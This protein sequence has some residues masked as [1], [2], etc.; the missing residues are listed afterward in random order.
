MNSIGKEGIVDF[1]SHLP[2]KVPIEVDPG[3][4]N[5]SAAV[6]FNRCGGKL[7]CIQRRKDHASLIRVS[8]RVVAAGTEI[9][10]TVGFGVRH[11]LIVTQPRTDRAVP[12]PVHGGQRGVAY[13]RCGSEGRVTPIVFQRVRL[14]HRLDQIVLR[15]AIQV[16]SR[17]PGAPE[18]GRCFHQ[19]DGRKLF[20][21]ADGDADP[22]GIE[23]LS[24]GVP[25]SEL[26]RLDGINAR[27]RQQGHLILHCP[28]GHRRT[29]GAAMHIVPIAV[30]VPVEPHVHVH[31]LCQCVLHRHLILDCG[32]LAGRQNQ[33]K[34]QT[35]IGAIPVRRPLERIEVV[36]CIFILAD[37]GFRLQT[38][39]LAEIEHASGIQMNRSVR[40]RTGLVNRRIVRD[41]VRRIGEHRRACDAVR[42]IRGITEVL[43][44]LPFFIPRDHEGQIE[45]HPCIAVLVG[46]N[47]LDPTGSARD[48][49]D[50]IVIPTTLQA[51]RFPPEGAPRR[52]GKTRGRGI[53]CHGQP[54]DGS[55]LLLERVVRD[56][57]VVL[58]GISVIV[59][60]VQTPHRIVPSLETVVDPVDS[61][62]AGMECLGPQKA[63]RP[64]PTVVGRRD[65][66]V[67]AQDK[68]QAAR[69][70][71]GQNIVAKRSPE[72]DVADGTALG[73]FEIIRQG[74]LGQVDIHSRR[75]QV[76]QLRPMHLVRFAGRPIAGTA[77]AG[78]DRQAWFGLVGPATDDD[79][80]RLR[81]D[82][83]L[84]PEEQPT[85]LTHRGAKAHV[86]TLFAE[87]ARS[88]QIS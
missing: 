9:R 46:I 17:R 64:A 37:V 33:G 12:G 88:K 39:R 3:L 59:P 52:R 14:N 34:K 11:I 43:L 5:P 80:V 6:D 83:R 32:R 30:P 77:F 35:V 76:G 71:G 55:L 67:D 48:G 60:Q 15:L 45:R 23:L 50:G 85:V 25:T 69:A 27:P 56:A 8:R 4:D 38:D 81:P 44:G 63:A 36:H 58:E 2:C 13:C 74:D 41:H 42:T 24:C 29:V 82:I 86:S 7:A 18:P 68:G 75:T 79:A 78:G 73:T 61:V 87:L 47:H 54:V 19:D 10:L 66:R 70:L 72:M 84:A 62:L 40:R 53:T 51:S 49:L 21:L 16:A 1:L 26:R 31:R 57:E 65:I 22:E 28:L 20:L